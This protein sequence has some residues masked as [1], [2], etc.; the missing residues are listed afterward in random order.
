MR[1]EVQTPWGKKG[2]PLNRKEKISFLWNAEVKEPRRLLGK[3]EKKNARSGRGPS[4]KK[5]KC[6]GKKGELGLGLQERGANLRTGRGRKNVVRYFRQG[7]HGKAR[8]N[9]SLHPGEEG[10][11]KERFD[12]IWLLIKKLKNRGEGPH[13][14]EFGRFCSNERQ[15]EDAFHGAILFPCP[16]ESV[17]R[18]LLSRR[19]KASERSLGERG[20]LR[21]ERQEKGKK[22]VDDNPPSASGGKGRPVPGKKIRTRANQRK[23]GPRTAC[24]EKTNC[25]A[26]SAT[27]GKGQKWITTRLKGRNSFISPSIKKRKVK[28]VDLQGNNR[29]KRA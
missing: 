6:E 12:S 8:V 27:E 26:I 25:L 17:R 7:R 20:G 19:K 18:C 13:G 28:K 14:P 22:T 5:N 1:W 29:E 9:S 15:G 21:M 2:V 23:K 3:G 10:P 16:R 4:E 24:H 11:P